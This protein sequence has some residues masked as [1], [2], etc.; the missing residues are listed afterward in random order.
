[1]KLSPT[2]ELNLEGWRGSEI[3]QISMLLEELF[4]TL[5]KSVLDVIFCGFSAERKGYPRVPQV[6][7]KSSR[8]GVQNS[9]G[10]LWLPD[11]S[12]NGC[13]VSKGCQKWLNIDDFAEC[14]LQWRIASKMLIPGSC[15]AMLWYVLLP[16]VLLCSQLYCSS[17]WLF[18]G[19]WA[20]ML[21]SL[22]LCITREWSLACLALSGPFATTGPCYMHGF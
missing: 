16:L 3:I 7:Q 13:R 2:R 1:M 15:W 14:F 11:P 10:S 22:S 9:L 20:L 4:P 12:Q 17:F 8:N 6:H 18:R 21:S 5:K 19:V